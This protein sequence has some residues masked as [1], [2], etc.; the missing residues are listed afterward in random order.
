[1]WLGFGGI[2]MKKNIKTL[3]TATAVATLLMAAKTQTA[4]AATSNAETKD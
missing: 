1:M 4:Q 2:N 3:Y